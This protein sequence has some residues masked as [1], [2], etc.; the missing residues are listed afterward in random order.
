MPD[1]HQPDEAD[2]AEAEATEAA[3]ETTPDLRPESEALQETRPSSRHDPS[4][5]DRPKT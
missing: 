4:A 3:E 5:P 1:F 2:R